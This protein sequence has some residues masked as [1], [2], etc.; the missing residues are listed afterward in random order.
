[1]SNT[2]TSSIIS[3]GFGIQFSPVIESAPTYEDYLSTALTNLVNGTFGYRDSDDFAPEGSQL[4]RFISDAYGDGLNTPSGATRPSARFI[5][6]AICHQDDATKLINPKGCSD[7][8]WLWGQFIDHD[9]D[10][11]PDGG[12]AFNI[13]VPTGDPHFDPESTGTVEIPLTRSVFDPATGTGVTPRAQLNMITSELD[14][15]NTYGSTTDRAN[16]LR[17]FKNGELKISSGNMLPIN[18]GTMD[19]A[20]TV[21]SN[22]FVAGDV[23]ANETVALLSLHT[24]MMRNHNWWA[25]KIKKVSPQMSDEEIYQRARVMVEGEVQ[26]ITFREFLPLL[27][28]SSAIPDYPGYDSGKSTQI[29][30]EFSTVAYRLGHSLISEEVLRLNNNDASIGSLTLREVFFAPDHY[31]NEGDINYIL[32]GFCKQKCQKL[33]AKLVN[34]LRNFLFGQPG[35]GGFD[36]AALNIQRGRDNGLTD[37][38]TMRDGYGLALK[39]SFADISSDPDVATALSVAYGGDLSLIDPWIGGLC[40][41]PVSESQ[42]GELF[43]KIVLNQF[44][45]VRGGDEFWYERRMTSGMINYIHRTTLSTIL[46]RNTHINNIQAKVMEL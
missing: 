5:S 28:G 22:P 11:T 44:E 14:C 21:G 31:S 35:N 29:A 37:Y 36:L 20:G 10:L 25:A 40:E 17:T 13:T 43:H 19:N 9:L 39:T 42:L 34:S 45:R 6:N 16:W 8:F 41:D 4:I 18:D 1:M 26:A 24:L 38:N 15:T 46:K 23:R 32:R 27:L 12:D 2:G 33:D 7:M 3:T 30:I